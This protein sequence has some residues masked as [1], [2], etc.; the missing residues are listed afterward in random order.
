MRSGGL[1]V[2][3]AGGS[4]RVPAGRPF[5]IGRGPHADLDLPHPRVSRRH[6]VV[7]LT[8][9]GWTLTDSSSNGTYLLQL[10]R[11]PGEV[12]AARFK[13]S[14]Q[15][16]RYVAA[17]TAAL[18]GVPDRPG[19]PRT[20]PRQQAGSR[21]CCADRIRSAGRGSGT[22]RSCPPSSGTWRS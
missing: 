4:V 12:L 13:A 11:V 14:A 9:G 8:A 17:P 10:D 19:A 18:P 2:R 3:H 1:E 16:R 21:S 15:H 5:V 22:P 7:E 20:T 6:A